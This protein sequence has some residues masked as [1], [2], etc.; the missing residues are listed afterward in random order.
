MKNGQRS[1]K[2]SYDIDALKL[3][4]E[5]SKCLRKESADHLIQNNDKIW[6]LKNTLM[7]LAGFY[8][9]FFTFV[10]SKES[11]LPDYDVMHIYPLILS[12]VFWAI[13]LY[14]TFCGIFPKYSL[15]EPDPCGIRYTVKKGE[16]ERHRRFYFNISLSL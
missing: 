13:A 15:F 7:I 10:Y 12:F 16:R 1:L 11:N 2:N 14:F 9:T 4:F 3:V 6:N 5:E 8:I